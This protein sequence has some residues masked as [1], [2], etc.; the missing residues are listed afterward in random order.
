MDYFFDFELSDLRGI[1]LY[2]PVR[3]T[4]ADL[5]DATDVKTSVAQALTGRGYTVKQTVGPWPLVS[6]NEQAFVA[7]RRAAY[8]RPAYPQRELPCSV[9]ASSKSVRKL[10]GPLRATVLDPKRTV[11]ELLAITVEL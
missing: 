1:P 11:Q 9:V 6:Q 10:W 5:D 7:E 3:A 4:A 2:L 8:E